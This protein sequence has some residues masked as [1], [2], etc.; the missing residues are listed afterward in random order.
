MNTNMGKHCISCK[1][2]GHTYLECKTLNFWGLVAG[3]FG[4]P[5]SSAEREDLDSGLKACGFKGEQ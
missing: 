5:M 3:A 2:D 4:V 1:Q